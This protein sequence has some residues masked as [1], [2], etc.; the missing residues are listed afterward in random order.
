MFEQTAQLIDKLVDGTLSKKYVWQKAVPL[1]GEITANYPIE[2]YAMIETH[3]SY[4]CKNNENM[5]ALVSM[6]YNKYSIFLY[7]YK[8]NEFSEYPIPIQ[9]YFRLRT[10]IQ[11][12]LGISDKMLNDFLNS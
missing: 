10:V 12:Q 8:S 3:K 1:P 9:S 4:W 5:V 2:T 7:S 11:N 6:H